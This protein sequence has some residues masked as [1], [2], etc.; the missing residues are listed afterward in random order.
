MKQENVLKLLKSLRNFE[1]KYERKWTRLLFL[2]LFGKFLLLTRRFSFLIFLTVE[3]PLRFIRR[4]QLRCNYLFIYI[5]VPIA[6]LIGLQAHEC[7]L[8]DGRFLN[9][10]EHFKNI[11]IK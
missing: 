8:F 9:P 11:N 5:S 3:R 10:L 2:F 1:R 6:L 4:R 7:Y